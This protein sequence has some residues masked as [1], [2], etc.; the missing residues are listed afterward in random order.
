MML[1][2]RWYARAMRGS[3][4]GKSLQ[5]EAADG[6]SGI[7]GQLTRSECGKNGPTRV[8]WPRGGEDVPKKDRSRRGA[9]R[10]RAAREPSGSEAEAGAVEPEAA[11]RG[12][13]EEE[14]PEVEVDGGVVRAAAGVGWR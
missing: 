5:A 8:E 9:E 6:K 11:A 13:E 7:A 14:G 2:P 12:E 4:K 1:N 10:M 3:M